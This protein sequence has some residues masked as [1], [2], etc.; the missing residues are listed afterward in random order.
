MPIFFAY[1]QLL[2]FSAFWYVSLTLLL[3]L[4]LLTFAST[5]ISR[6]D[7]SFH[8]PQRDALQ[9]QLRVHDCNQQQGIFWAT[10]RIMMPEGVL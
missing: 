5:R 3:C 1:I 10:F 6:P 4:Y 2:I 7:C 9:M 8:D